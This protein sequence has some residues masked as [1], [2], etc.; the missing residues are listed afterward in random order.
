MV[1]IEELNRH[2]GLAGSLSFRLLGDEMAVAVINTGLCTARIAL[3]GAQL[4][5]WTPQG[6][7]PVIWLS[8]DTNLIPGKSIR[9]GTP[10]C[11]PWFGAHATKNDYPAHGYARTVDWEIISTEAQTDGRIKLAFRLLTTEA[12]HAL[13]PHI[14]PVELQIILGNTLELE[15]ITRNEEPVPITITE[16]LHTYFTVGDVRQVNVTGLDGCDYLDKV[17]NF[18]QFTQQGVVSFNDEVDRVYLNSEAACMIEDA[19]WDR[20][21]HIKK[22]GSHT[23]IVWNPWIDKALAMGDMGKDGY[24]NMLCVESGNAA[25]NVVTIVPGGEH[26]LWVEYQVENQN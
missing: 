23:T 5:E 1:D 8:S 26:R 7:K 11:W 18:E 13:W 12:T 16:A 19:S 10:V 24:L 14:S 4:L 21:I 22:R 15:L 3:Q 2:F 9:G 17:K 6:Q 25:D 20:R